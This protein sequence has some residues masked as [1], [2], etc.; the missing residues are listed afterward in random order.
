MG[1]STHVIGLKPPN[2]K[3]KKMLEVYK[4]CRD[5]NIVVP[6]EVKIY[7]Y[8]CEPREEEVTIDIPNKEWSE[9]TSQVIEINLD[10]IDKDIRIIRFYN[11]I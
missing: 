8:Q 7:F 2:D 4:N 11:S 9:N 5:L 3:H 6:E 1:M 10:E